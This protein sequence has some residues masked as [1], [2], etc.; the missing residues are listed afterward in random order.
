MRSDW[1]LRA[2]ENA[3][4]YIDCGHGDSP[5]T[6]WKSGEVDVK[7]LVL[8]GIDLA[9]GSTV[10]E[11]GCGIGRL[12]RPLG[13]R[14]AHVIGV[15]ISGEMI[16]RAKRELADLPHL[17]LFRTDGSLRKVR[18]GSVD[19]VFSFIVF[20]HVV[21]ESAVFAYF[22]E[23]AA[24]LRPGGVFRFQA[25]GRASEEIK[26]NSWTGVRLG[27]PEL[28]RALGDNNLRVLEISSP[29]TQYMWVT[30]QKDPADSADRS[31]IRFRRR[32][33]NVEALR[34]LLARAGQNNDAQ[35]AQILNGSHAVRDAVY[36]FFQ[37]QRDLSAEDYV[38]LAYSV[39]L[40]R[41]A[42]PGGLAFYSGEITD[43]IG[44]SNVVDCLL[45]S[46]EFDEGHR[47]FVT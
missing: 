26:T 13:K 25:D 24:A 37:T 31:S 43:G 44:R 6:F 23:A 14:G 39:I 34:G 42:D 30:A 11:I 19:F 1:D 38:R 33:W 21:S 28:T 3:F 16:A 41:T 27:V 17:T 10:L 35:L 9:P 46:P 40:G 7:D 22:R 4:Y 45:S 15:D 36:P 18:R 20:Q 47:E 32:G 2:R 29:G 5:E 8:R 12:L